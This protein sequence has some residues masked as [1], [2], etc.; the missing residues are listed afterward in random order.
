MGSTCF[1]CGN[2][3]NRIIVVKSAIENNDKILSTQTIKDS[4]GINII[5]P[6]TRKIINH[7]LNQMI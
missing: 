2:G 5:N 3:K 1:S 6:K 4:K 7:C